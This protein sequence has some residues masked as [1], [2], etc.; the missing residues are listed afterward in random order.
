MGIEIGLSKNTQ[1]LQGILSLQAANLP[2]N[3][4]NEEALEQGFVTI[5]HSLELLESFQEIEPQLI[6]KDDQSI[7]AYILAMTRASSETIPILI[8]MFKVFEEIELDG[9]PVSDYNYLVVGQVCVAKD[10]RGM[11]LFDLCYEAYR[12]FFQNRYD[13]VITEISDRNPR[14]IKAHERVGFQVVHRYPAEYGNE[15]VVVLWDWRIG[16]H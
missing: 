8:P 13:F 12:D 6:A 1:D 9:R 2:Q 7:V 5:H 11:G 3:L 14:S 16:Q 10:Y 15:W 4:T